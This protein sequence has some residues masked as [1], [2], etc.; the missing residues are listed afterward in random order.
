MRRTII[1]DT[2]CLIVLS[3]IDELEILR[4]I[5]GQVTVTP[6]VIA[7]FG[8][9]LP[10]W[11]EILSP[12]DRSRQEELE[13]EIDLGEASSIALALETPGS[14]LIIDD[15]RARKVAEKL[16]LNFTGTLGVIAKAKLNGIIVSVKP[17]LVKIRS[18][19]FRVSNEVL[20]NVLREAGE[21]D[22]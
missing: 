8:G 1:S 11:F 16:G 3:N 21:E 13:L 12:K 6:E 14:T 5:Y 19:K 2:S 20:Q 22:R 18:T 15:L 10:D 7:E 9:S 4:L 17:I